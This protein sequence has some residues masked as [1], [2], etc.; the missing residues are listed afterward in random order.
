MHELGIVFYIIDD[1]EEVAKQN[2]LT[3]VQSVTMELGEVSG[4]VPSYLTDVWKWA[5]QKHDIMK[6]A[7]L[8]CES[9][10]AVT[11]CEDCQRTYETVKYG[12]TCPH[13]GSGSTYLLRGNEI[14]IKQIE[15]C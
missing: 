4:V 12:K 1:V 5:V 10:P 9:T 3:K 8:I 13:C 7:E 14:N 11:Y 6:D 15:A 2:A